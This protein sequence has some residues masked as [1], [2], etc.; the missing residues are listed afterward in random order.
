MAKKVAFITGATSGIG[1]AFA[2]EFAQRKYD[3][4]LTGRREEKIKSLAETLRTA[5]GVG[6]EVIIADLAYEDTLAALAEKI[7]NLSQL[8]V[9]IN[10]AGFA[11][12]EKFHNAP[13]DIFSYM[14][15]SQAFATMKLTHAALPRMLANKAG[16][17]I[18]VSSLAAFFPHPPHATYA[19][20]KAS[21][22]SFTESLAAEHKTSGVRFQALCPGATRSDFHEKMALDVDKLYKQRGWL[23]KVATGEQVVKTSL[24]CLAKNKVICIPGVCNKIIA[25]KRTLQRLFT[26]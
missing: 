26:I 11:S 6:V 9:L 22:N 13:F 12:R 2:K 5:Y 16:A 24:H 7:R 25:V 1:A 10:N 14:L 4:I 17:I 21:I 20:A 23:W 8:E 19:A 3:L 18:N 15:K